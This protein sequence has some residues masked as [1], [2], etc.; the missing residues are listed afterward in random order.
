MY[1]SNRFFRYIAGPSAVTLIALTAQLTNQRPAQAQIPTS[2][3]LTVEIS[4]LKNS[5]GQVCL[6]LFDGS[7]GFPDDS[8]AVIATQCIDAAEMDTATASDQDT[9]ASLPT[10][11]FEDLSMG[12]YAVTIF[13]DEN[14]DGQ[15]N[16]AT[17]G[18]PT[19]GFG[20]S[21]NPEIGT[22]AP[23]FYETAVFVFGETTTQIEMI[24]F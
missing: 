3:S 4:A 2:G 12:T 5:V 22:S 15:I 8:D 6:S 14:G 23:A 20:F 24:Y 9:E 19:E 16:R 10:V 13:H 7:A 21:R 1:R 11:T 17:F 18:I